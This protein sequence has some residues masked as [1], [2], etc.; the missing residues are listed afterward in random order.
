MNIYLVWSDVYESCDVEAIFDSFDDAK[1]FVE[2][3]WREFD[4]RVFIE[5]RTLGEWRGGKILYDAEIAGY[6]EEDK[7][8]INERI[9]LPN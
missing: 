8:L 1:S 9:S 2:E 3:H 7:E 5:Y 6:A 4:F